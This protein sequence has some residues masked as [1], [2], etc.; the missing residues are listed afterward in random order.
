[1]KEYLELRNG[2]YYFIGSRIS[3]AAIYYPFF[4]DGA[5]PETIQQDYSSYLTL[6]K[7]YGA[8]LA[9]A[10]DSIVD[11]CEYSLTGEFANAIYWANTL[12]FVY[13]R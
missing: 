10:I 1:M 13:F 5:S 11:A 8:S 2:G 6:E 12:G 7:V 3:L 9:S 4:R